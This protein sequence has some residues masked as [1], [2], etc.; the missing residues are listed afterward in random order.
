MGILLA[1]AY[2]L[3]YPLGLRTLA[4]NCILISIGSMAACTLAVFLLDFLIW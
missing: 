1:V 3:K 4:R 2:Y